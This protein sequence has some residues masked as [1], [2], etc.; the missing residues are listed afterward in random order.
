M[1]S[2]DM[3]GFEPLSNTRELGV[4]H[5]YPRDSTKWQKN[6][7]LI[8]QMALK[9]HSFYASFVNNSSNLI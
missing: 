3:V 8:N 7:F 5:R 2:V 4:Q 6:N 9:L 1:F